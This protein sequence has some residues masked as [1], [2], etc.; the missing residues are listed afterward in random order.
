MST[1]TRIE[2]ILQ[3]I[4]DGNTY[5]NQPLSRA[6]ELL[7]LLKPQID[8]AMIYYILTFDGQHF[9]HDG[10]MLTFAQIHEKC[11]DE[12]HFVYAQYENNLYIPQFV[13]ATL[14][15]FD[16]A[17]IRT[18]EPQLHRL[19]MTRVGAVTKQDVMLVE[20]DELDTLKQT[21]QQM[22]VPILRNA[23][24]TTDQSAAIDA[25]EQAIAAD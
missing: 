6:E 18:D 2:E 16:A 22:L 25:F 1:Q 8:K 14:I 5:T 20:K 15:F 3:S 9:K 19:C 11:L 4:I 13:S 17:Y 21:I 12:K 10:E 7:L 23:Q 24:Y